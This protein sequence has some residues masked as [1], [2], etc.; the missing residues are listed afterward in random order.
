MRKQFLLL[1]ALCLAVGQSWAERIDVATAREVARTVASRGSTLR[2]AGELSLVYAAAPGQTG[3]ALRSAS[4]AGDADYF[5]FNVPGDG[6]FVIVAGDDRV[7]P[8]LGY[9][10]TG[11]FDPDN[12]PENLRGMLAYYQNQI[13]WAED[14]A[15]EASPAISAEWSQYQS[16]TALRAAGEKVLPNIANWNQYEPYNKFVPKFYWNGELTQAVTGC[17]ATATAIIMR[18]HQ[19]PKEVVTGGVTH[20]VPSD[21]TPYEYEKSSYEVSYAPYDWANMPLEYNY[22]A[23]TDAQANAVAALMWNIGANVNMGYGPESAASTHLAAGKLRQLFGYG[24]G[25]RVVSKSNYT[26]ED[27]KALIRTEIDNDRPILYDG[28]RADGSSGHAFVCDG[29]NSDDHFHF[30]WGWGGYCNGYFLLTVMNPSDPNPDAEPIYNMDNSMAIGIKPASASDQPVKEIRYTDLYTSV[31]PL[32]S[33]GQTFMVNLEYSNVGSTS[34]DA[35]LNLAVVDAAG[36]WQRNISEDYNA[37]LGFD[38]VYLGG[39]SFYTRTFDCRLDAALAQ[40]E[41]ILPVY[42]LDGGSTWLVMGRSEEAA[43]Y[44][45]QHGTIHAGDDPDNPDLEMEATLDWNAFDNQLLLA[46]G[47]DETSGLVYNNT[48]RINYQFKN[49]SEGIVMRFTF[50]DF[51]AWCDRVKIYYS[52][53]EN[54]SADVPGT[55]LEVGPDGVADI[56]VTLDQIANPKNEIFGVS[57]RVLSDKVGE[58]PY[59]L[60]LF[61]E[62]DDENPIAEELDKKMKFIS[63]PDYGIAPN[64]LRGVVGQDIDFTVKVR[65][66][67]ASLLA[68]D[69]G[70]SFYIQSETDLGQDILIYRIVD[71]QEVELDYWNHGSFYYSGQLNNIGRLS[72]GQ[73]LQFRLK[74]IQREVSNNDWAYVDVNL[75]T[76]EGSVALPR[77]ENPAYIYV[78]NKAVNTHD[79]TLNLEGLVTNSPLTSVEDNHGIWL[80]LM[81][82]TGYALPAEIEISMGGSVLDNNSYYYNPETG[83]VSIQGITGDLVITAKGVEKAAYTYP[84]TVNVTNLPEVT[85]PA[86]PENKPVTVTLQS[87]DAYDLPDA[88]TVT[89]GGEALT[90]DEDYTYDSST[91]EVKI[92]SVT[93]PIVITAI[94]KKK[95]VYFTITAHLSHLICPE[96][97]DGPIE[98]IMEE[99]EFLF[100]LEPE[101]GYRLP[102]AI[103]IRKADTENDYLVA[104]TDY[105]YSR[106]SNTYS[107]VKI[108][109][110]NA[111]LIVEAT[112]IADSHY[113]V[114][115][116]MSGVKYETNAEQQYL[117]DEKPSFT[118][119]LSAATG[120]TYVDDGSITVKMGDEVLEAGTD[121]IYVPENDSFE[122][123]V[124]LR[125]TLTISAQGTKERYPITVVSETIGTSLAEDETVEYGGSITFEVIPRDGY[126]LLDDG[127]S[128]VVSVNGDP[129]DD[130]SYDQENATITINNV[131]GPVSVTLVGTAMKYAVTL[132]LMHLVADEF[133]S[134]TLVEH[135]QPFDITLVAQGGY[136]LPE[137][138][139]VTMGEQP[140]EGAY[141]EGKIHI[142]KVTGP[143]V[144][145]AVAANPVTTGDVVYLTSAFDS[146]VEYGETLTGTLTA[147]EGYRLPY[148]IEVLM[149]GSPLSS[150][151]YTYNNTT[152]EVKIPNVTGPIVIKAQGISDEQSEVVLNCTGVNANRTAYTVV[153][154]DEPLTIVL[155]VESGYEEPITLTV[156]MNGKTLVAG[157]DYT[158]EDGTFAINE[159]NGTLIITATAKTPTPDPDPDPTP[160]PDPTPTPTTYIVTLP[161]VEGATI[162]AVGSTSVKAGDSFSFT[163]TVKEGYVATNMVVKANGVTLTPNADGRYTISDVR[164]NVV[165]T[166]AGI[167]EDPATAIESVDTS[168]LKV[169]AADGRLFIQ[170]PRTDKA[171]VVTFDGR[172]YK[173]LDLPAGETVTPMPQG[174]YIIYVGELS[175]KVVL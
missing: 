108:L 134:G 22:N 156:R 56:S 85:V 102:D 145:T 105:E 61:A 161:V 126:E 94:G 16:G 172:L 131:T 5:V 106:Y 3:S 15:V 104:G 79:V 21:Y 1:M 78:T 76:N 118:L 160:G 43:L 174:A 14:N 81:P 103:K 159:L 115:F 90:L 112:A 67:D 74:N 154:N 83:E 26:W 96:F 6:G 140:V 27:W 91:G 125:G 149:G 33:V 98:G 50:P 52:V 124:P 142:E 68:E 97:S 92:N 2:S 70:M 57:M 139:T 11:S 137:A 34:F 170:T 44:I 62:S 128:I 9:S 136:I 114:V 175:F 18:Y 164:S 120:H 116:D 32:P 89:M 42:S 99:S 29:Y 100:T 163:V 133:A 20:F 64:P 123:K 146:S 46:F 167:E 55:P 8:V 48:Q 19:H 10:H 17:V 72:I 25:L 110:V 87:N 111:N 168:G 13:T 86:A 40:G 31:A 36:N 80:Q 75:F 157:T 63:V 49:A 65:D 138:I 119:S 69:M 73:E 37:S 24:E 173:A 39:Y 7:R 132:N 23:Y 107:L 12:L 82:K 113:E 88:I 127:S 53:E 28:Q 93:G 30:N 51:S 153:Q 147:G 141:Q 4:A 152:G 45:N 109:S 151:A 117:I 122:L 54:I 47:L 169:W 41:K 143:V 171:Y 121:Y 58:L 155:T 101:E 135:G 150:N 144:I 130:F 38:E 129:H 148:R 66:L 158:F 59:N 35:L 71:G 77:V 165:V 60:Q 166:V 95:P 84:V 162:E